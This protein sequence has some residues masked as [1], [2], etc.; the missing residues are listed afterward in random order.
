MTFPNPMNRKIAAVG[1]LVLVSTLACDL[2]VPQPQAPTATTAPLTGQTPGPVET[3]EVVTPSVTEEVKVAPG[4]ILLDQ[5]SSISSGASVEF[6][7]DGVREQVIGIEVTLVSGKPSYQ[8]HLVDKFG[9]F[10]AVFD[11]D[12]NLITENVP[13]FT[14]PYGGN[15]KVLLTS[16]SGDG[17]LEVAGTVGGKPTGGGSISHF[18]TVLN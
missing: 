17:T 4:T 10:I 1:A 13:E 7:F 2:P 14:L 3:G 18:G 15:Y 8:F 16:I 11:S 12:P 6:S 9:N 5:T